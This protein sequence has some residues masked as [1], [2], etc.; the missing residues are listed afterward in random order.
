MHGAAMTGPVWLIDLRGEAELSDGTY[1]VDGAMVR[2]SDHAVIALGVKVGFL[3]QRTAWAAIETVQKADGARVWLSMSSAALAE[4]PPDGIW[5][6]SDLVVRRGTETVGTLGWIGVTGSVIPEIG[7]LPSDPR[8]G[9]RRLAAEHIQE[10]NDRSI[11]I[12]DVELADEPDLRTDSDMENEVRR[13]L[14]ETV[15][16]V[17]AEALEQIAVTVEGGVVTISGMVPH[18]SQRALAESIAREPL[19]VRNVVNRVQ[20]AESLG[21]RL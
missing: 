6:R 8:I 17:P 15:G 2:A 9:P 5:L 18:D 13:R 4:R 19:E 3:G 7:I 11:Q 12:G 21:Q 10:L 16:S 14:W 20:S 1:S